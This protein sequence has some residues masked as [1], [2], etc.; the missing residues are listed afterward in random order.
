MTEQQNK[1]TSLRGARLANVVV[2][3]LMVVI[4]WLVAIQFIP[5]VM[6]SSHIPI[7]ASTL[8]DQI[9]PMG[10]MIA[11]ALV[12]G[13][14]AIARPMPQFD[15][16]V[17][18]ALIP[19]YLAN[20]VI[21]MTTAGYALAYFLF[22]ILLIFFMPMFTEAALASA[23]M[24][25]IDS[26]LCFVLLWSTSIPLI[27]VHW[28]KQFKDRP[29]S[30]WP[31][32]IIDAL[33]AV[34]LIV[35]WR[36]DAPVSFVLNAGVI[37]VGMTWL[38]LRF[39][40]VRRVYNSMLLMSFVFD[41]PTA[42]FVVPWGQRWETMETGGTT[43]AGDNAETHGTGE[44]ADAGETSKVSGT[45]GSVEP[46]G[47]ETIPETAATAGSVE[48]DEAQGAAGADETAETSE[49]PDSPNRNG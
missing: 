36:Y 15:F 14:L 43:G 24:V 49:S 7:E 3:G 10:V 39:P 12:R 28:A 26:A 2:S 16:W 23:Q 33:V 40:D 20:L 8:G 27:R 21:V 4:S 34:F 19:F 46:A 47:T 6:M 31:M 45:N 35:L 48:S 13:V 37:L 30:V 29:V 1:K 44:I 5:A 22:S 41:V 42:G 38:G 9:A 17:K 18:I 25:M 32:I 11:L